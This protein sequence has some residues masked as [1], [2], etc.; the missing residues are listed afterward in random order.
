MLR[1]PVGL[2]GVIAALAAVAAAGLL[3]AAEWP[4]YRG[5]QRNGTSGERGLAETWGGGEPAILWRRS[6]GAGYSG[7]TSVGPR[8]YTMDA[9]SE[10]EYLLSLDAAT[11]RT[12]WRIPVSRFV[13]AELGDGGPRSTPTVADGVVYAVSYSARLLSVAAVDGR[14]IWD[15]DLSEL[16]PV[17]R[18]G[19]AISPLVDGEE[20][21]LEVG[22]QGEGPGVAA[23]ERSTGKLSWSALQGPAGYSSAIVAEIADRRQY[24]LFRAAGRELVGLSTSGEVLWRY[25]TAEALSAIP[26]PLFQPPDRIFVSTSEDAFGG[27]MLRVRRGEAGFEVEEDWSE[28]LMRNHFNSSVLAG[29]HLYGF[30][31]GT[32][33]CLDAA[34]GEHR[35]ARRGFGK[36]SLIAAD[37]RLFVL[38]DGGTLALVEATPEGYRE[39]GR[40]QIMEGRSWTEPS[41][42]D[43]R[44]YAR[45]F[46]EIVSVEVRAGPSDREPGGG[47]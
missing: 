26:M 16:G 22:K 15:R 42:A 40:V 41:L 21:V 29:G 2:S 5:P 39:T 34:T 46:D 25:A 43:G 35:W 8:L 4:Q 24:V 38:G 10:Q 31:N 9:D 12:I 28:R 37:G 17:P 44:L 47:R 20:V 13:Q 30:D 19:Y 33:R 32:L 23:F 6:I 1:P 11:G 45:D 36:G 3:A 14:V 18:F 27:R 7:V